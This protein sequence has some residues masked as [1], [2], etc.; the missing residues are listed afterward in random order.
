MIEA[1]L[2]RTGKGH[3]LARVV[4]RNINTICDIQDRMRQGRSA[5]DRVADRINTFAGSMTFVY[6]HAAWFAAWMVINLGY[7]PIKPFDPEPF[8]LL[9]LVVSLEAI[10]L[11]AFILVSQNRM[12]EMADKRADLDLQINLLAEYEVTRL[13]KVAD[14]IAEHLGVEEGHDPEVEELKDEVSP[15][16]VMEEMDRVKRESK[17]AVAVAKAGDGAANGNGRGK[18]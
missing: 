7:T 13:L 16:K 6:L 15:E 10:F 4:E 5:S 18:R 2:A 14:A 3:G 9:T 8:G 1:Q 17:E 11:S 12:T